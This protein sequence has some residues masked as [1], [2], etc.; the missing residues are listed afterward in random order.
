MA[1]VTFEG[2]RY[3]LHEG[4][5]VLDALLRGG[6]NVSFSC[7]RGSCQACLLRATHGDPGDDAR[8]TLRAAMR[9]RGYFLPCL[10]KPREDLTVERPDLSELFVRVVVQEKTSLSRDVV[11]LRLEPETNLTWRAGQYVNVRR[12]DGLVRSYS[13][14]SIPEEDYYLEL[15]VR[16]IEGGA[17]STFLF[18]DVRVGDELEI[19]GP[20]GTCFYDPATRA[21]PLLLVGGGTGLAPLVGIARDALRQGHEGEVFLYH[22]ARARDGLYLR[23]ELEALAA[24]EPRL[25]FVA[26]VSDADPGPGVE[27]GLVTDVAFARHPDLSRFVVFLCGA[28]EMVHDARVRAYAAGASRADTHADPFEPARPYMP[29]DSAKLRSIPSEPEI[30][31]ALREGPGLSEI[32]E[33]F[34]GK[35]YEDPRLAPFFHKITKKRAIEKQYEFLSSLFS[36]DWRYFGLNPF[37][38]HHWMVISDELF[39]Y[40][41]AL[42]DAAL[43]RYGLEERLIRRWGAL[44]ERFRRELVKGSPR[45]LIVNGVEMPVEG[46]TEETTIVGTVCDGCMSEMPPGTRGRMHVRTG[47]LFCQSC[48]A[49]EVGA[50]VPPPAA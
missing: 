49:R 16:R 35:V 7:R 38:A 32:L 42:F 31:A 25:R 28:P 12:A 27:R 15:H 26:C 41:E 44:H 43:R 34:Y 40:R 8:R 33:D 9:E 17:M 47:E 6:A 1:R 36:G 2:C 45:G 48:S 39:D 5:R 14:A 46:Y 37:N 18:D 22:G 23:E 30:W 19:Q 4:E 11:R 20:V 13:L 3:P 24:S 50:T 10:A 21:R 29:D